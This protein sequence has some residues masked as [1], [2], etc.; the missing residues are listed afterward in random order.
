MMMNLFDLIIGQV[1]GS[2]SYAENSGT[3]IIPYLIHLLK[4]LEGYQLIMMKAYTDLVPLLFMK[5][6][7]KLIF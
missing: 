5:K 2:I 4:I 6:I 1:D 7:M 3:M